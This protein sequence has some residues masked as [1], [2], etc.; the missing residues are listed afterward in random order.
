MQTF[1]NAGKFG[2]DITT[3]IG[4]LLGLAA[5]VLS[6]IWEGGH[7]EMVLAGPAMFIVIGG[8]IGASMVTTTLDTVLNI[9]RY[10]KIAFR[11]RTTDH[12]GTIEQIVR[13]AERARRDGI[14]GLENNL[15]GIED[16]FFKKAIQLVIDGTEVTVLR[17]I[18]ETEISYKAERHNRGIG[19]FRTMGGFSPTMGIIGT[20]LGLIHTLA[21]TDDPA[22]MASAIASAFI[23][24]LWGVALANLAWIPIAEK[25]KLRHEE[26]MTTLELI[27]EGVVSIQSGDNPRMI[28]TK[29]TSFITPGSRVLV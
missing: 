7:L 4:L 24:T 16:P 21:N 28:R 18:L 1:N 27:T 3:I 29:L 20:V 25:L 23:A 19:L 12:E 26:E 15:R 5:I 10:L 9:P 17:A 6:F 22:R 8:T 14:L 11:G 2:V 13:M